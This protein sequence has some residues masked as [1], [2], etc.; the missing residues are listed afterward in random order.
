MGRLKFESLQD[1][2]VFFVIP[3]RSGDFG[4]SDSN[5]SRFVEYNTVDILGYLQSVSITDQDSS[6]GGV[7]D[8]GDKSRRCSQ[9]Q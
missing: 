5:G 3:L 6:G 4:M 8:S 1:R 7:A 2:F 9:S